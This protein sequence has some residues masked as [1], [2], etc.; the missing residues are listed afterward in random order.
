MSDLI[1]ARKGSRDSTDRSTGRSSQNGGR[2]MRR[3][4]SEV[5]IDSLNPRVND[6]K[7]ARIASAKHGNQ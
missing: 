6:Q 3:L 7:N 2:S 4:K 1:G 5:L